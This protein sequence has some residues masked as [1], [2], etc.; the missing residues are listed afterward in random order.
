MTDVVKNE[1]K[2]GF[3]FITTD[4]PDFVL[5]GAAEDEFLIFSEI[6]ALV[7]QPVS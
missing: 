6:G 1:L 7:N 3:G 4:E 2:S 5:V